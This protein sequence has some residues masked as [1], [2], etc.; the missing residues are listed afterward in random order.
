LSSL[1]L[2][3]QLLE[4]LLGGLAPCICLLG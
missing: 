4:L 1:D 3:L 2:L